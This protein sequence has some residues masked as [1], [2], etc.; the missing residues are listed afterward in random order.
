MLRKPD[1]HPSIATEIAELDQ[2][3]SGNAGPRVAYI[4]SRFLVGLPI[5]VLLLIVP[6]HWH[7]GLMFQVGTIGLYAALGLVL[8]CWSRPQS[9]IAQFKPVVLLVY[10]AMVNAAAIAAVWSL[11]CGR[12]VYRWEPERH[13]IPGS[14]NEIA[15][16][17]R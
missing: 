11:I 4:M 2:P 16:T 6:L 5:L 10:F 8:F 1:H 9:R 15:E 17:V 7:T 12:R 14:V 13:A 3:V